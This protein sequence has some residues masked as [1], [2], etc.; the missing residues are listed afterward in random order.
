METRL[1]NLNDISEIMPII[2]DA[3]AFMKTLN[4]DQ[5]QNNYP[6]E[7]DFTIDINKKQC[8]VT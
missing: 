3:Q 1:A 4:M 2:H 6:N 7:S 8:Y 5:W